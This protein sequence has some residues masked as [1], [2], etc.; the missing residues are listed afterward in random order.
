MPTYIT[1][2]VSSGGAHSSFTFSST[3]IGTAASDRYVIVCLQSQPNSATGFTS[4][5]IGGTGA[6]AVMGTTMSGTTSTAWVLNV[7]SGTTADIVVT[8]SGGTCWWSHIY[9]YT[10]SGEPTV[11]DYDSDNTINYGNPSLEVAIDIPAS[12]SA[13][14]FAGQQFRT[15]TATW[16]GV[17]ED[18]DDA[19]NSPT[20]HAGSASGLGSE[21]AR[22]ISVFFSDNFGGDHGLGALSYSVSSGQSMSGTPSITATTA[23]GAIGVERGLS[24][25]PSITAATAAGAMGVERGMSGTPTLA[26]VTATG[27]MSHSFGGQEMSGTPSVTALTAAGSIGVERALAGSVSITALTV[28]GSM[29][30]ERG[31]SGTP[32]IT[33][34]TGSGA[35]GVERGMSGTPTLPAVTATGSM[36]VVAG[37]DMTGAVTLPGV[38]VTGAMEVARSVTGTPT[39]PAVTASGTMTVP[40]AVAQPIQGG[41]G[42]YYDPETSYNQDDEDRRIRQDREARRR[43]VER[44]FEAIDPAPRPGPVPRKVVRAV[45]AEARK[46]VDLP[47]SALRPEIEEAW[48]RWRTFQAEMAERQKAERLEAKRKE[49]EALMVLLLVA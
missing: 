31:M 26:A 23:S 42:Y 46:S 32:S 36:T 10:E 17:T 3:S 24:G 30:V 49:D 25:T 2:A 48:A 20:A 22:T 6:T 18:V 9:V 7:T 16:V 27:S 15:P 35:M 12:G 40:S 45:A 34:L 38:T 39:L 8:Y 5:T 19:T 43:A 4:V 41:W 33:A 37:A 21:T 47:Q 13:I 1:E 29:G 11:Y 44:A 14:G 28:A